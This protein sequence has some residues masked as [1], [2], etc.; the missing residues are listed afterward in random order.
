MSSDNLA[1]LI[2]YVGG[3]NLIFPHHENEIACIQRGDHKDNGSLTGHA[4]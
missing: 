4:P 2:I 1:N 3:I